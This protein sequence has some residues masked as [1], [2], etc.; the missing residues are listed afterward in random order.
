MSVGWGSACG[1]PGLCAGGGWPSASRPP[2]ARQGSPGH[3]PSSTRRLREA[4]R[5]ET[6]TFTLPGLTTGSETSGTMLH[7]ILQPLQGQR[8][9]LFTEG[10]HRVPSPVLPAG[11]KCGT[12]RAPAPLCLQPEGLLSR[13]SSG[14]PPGAPPL[15]AQR[16]N[17]R[18]F[19]RSQRRNNGE[20]FSQSC[21]VWAQVTPSQVCKD[22]L[23]YKI[24]FQITLLKQA[25]RCTRENHM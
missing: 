16:W 3:P 4:G 8:H 9:V 19:R 17:R 6:E 5:V 18:A 24:R 20:C 1:H 11:K 21:L 12:G 7:C 15:G 2:L 13:D 25:Q 14:S 23:L 10:R 22:T